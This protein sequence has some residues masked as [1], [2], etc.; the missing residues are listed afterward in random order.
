[1][2]TV[3]TGWAL[4]SVFFNLGRRGKEDIFLTSLKHGPLIIHTTNKTMQQP[5]YH[6]LN[7]P[8]RVYILN[9]ATF[10]YQKALKS[11]WGDFP[12]GPGVKTP[13]FHT[14]GPGL[15]HGW[16]TKTP[17]ATK[18]GQKTKKQQL[19]IWTPSSNVRK[20]FKA[21]NLDHQNNVQF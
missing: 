17:C 7:L 2:M 3:N 14:K 11:N 19:K 4:Y 21:W 10:N 9:I 18:C 5:K 20:Q 16:G 12:G 8:Q 13:G 15:I 6:Y 1:M